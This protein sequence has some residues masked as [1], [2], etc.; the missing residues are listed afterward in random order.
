MH[1]YTRHVSDDTF[2]LESQ[3]L[4]DMEAELVTTRA[5]LATAA[6]HTA[7]VEAELFAVAHRLT[8]KEA[9][10]EAAINALKK[11]RDELFEARAKAEELQAEL[12][13]V[14]ASTP[15]AS[16]AERAARKIVRTVKK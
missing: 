15:K 4:Q 3:L 6:A 8:A 12:D 5:E 16:F 9:E 2:T 7:E 13:R 10:H 1:S 11:M 14:R